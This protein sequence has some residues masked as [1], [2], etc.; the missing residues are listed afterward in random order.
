MLALIIVALILGITVD[1]LITKVTKS[2]LL[3]TVLGG[4]LTIAICLIF[5]Q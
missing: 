3:G 4:A 2:S 5:W 1:A